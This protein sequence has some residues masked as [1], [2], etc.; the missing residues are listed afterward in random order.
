[1][2]GGCPLLFPKPFSGG[3]IRDSMSGLDGNIVLNTTAF[4]MCL[5]EKSSATNYCY[6]PGYVGGCALR[7][8]LHS[9]QL[10]TAIFFFLES[11]SPRRP[12]SEA[13]WQTEFY[14]FH[15]PPQ[16]PQAGWELFISW[17]NVG[18]GAQPNGMMGG[19]G[20]RCQKPEFILAYNLLDDGC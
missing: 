6:E 19:G 7:W 1:M 3:V 20:G 12:F 2:H 13:E 11:C 15:L 9:L 4:L 17:L 5:W 14:L 8:S 16:D 10:V 18:L